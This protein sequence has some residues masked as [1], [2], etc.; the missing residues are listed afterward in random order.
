[1]FRLPIGVEINNLVDDLK[2]ISWKA[3]DILYYYSNKLKNNSLNTELIKYKNFDD[4]VTIADLKVNNL[5]IS[6]IKKRYPETDWGFLSEEKGAINND[7][8]YSKNKWLWVLDPLDGTKDFI[9]NTGEYAMHLALNY[10]NIPIL[11]IVLIPSREELWIANGTT[12]WFENRDGSKQKPS[13]SNEKDIKDMT[14]VTSKNHRNKE[15]KLLINKLGFSQILTMGSIGY[16]IT[17]IM[18]GE[19]DVYISL[20]I[21]GKSFPK[22]WDFAAPDVI[23]STCGGIIT[24]YEN[25]KLTY[26]KKDFNQSGIIIASTNENIQRKLCLAIKKVIIENNIIQ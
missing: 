4:P 11:G 23:L 22:D 18:R 6:E 26:N 9:Q 20:S 10:M 12:V 14:I 19:S 15:L 7:Y 24:D 16:K 5:V 8:S 2:T 1:M 25:K 3:F 21:P 13:L 17:S